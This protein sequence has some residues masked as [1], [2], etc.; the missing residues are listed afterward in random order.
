LNSILQKKIIDLGWT[1][2]QKEGNYSYKVSINSVDEYNSCIEF[3]QKT[4]KDI[5]GVD[6]IEN[7]MIELN[8]E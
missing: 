1:E 5:F 4:A 2:P 3:I 6:V 8:L 7:S